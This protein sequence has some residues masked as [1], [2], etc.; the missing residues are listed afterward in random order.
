MRLNAFFSKPAASAP[1]P[2]NPVLSSPQKSSTQEVSNPVSPAKVQDAEQSSYRKEFPAFF[3]QSNTI[4]SPPHRFERDSDALD[5][6]RQKIDGFL[7]QPASLPAYRGSE[8]FDMV[9]YRRRNG[10]NIVSVKTLLAN[11]QNN[12]STVDPTASDASLRDHLKKITM[13]TIRFGEDVRP[14]YY[15]TF[16][17]RLSYMQTL[18]ICR[19]PYSRILP[20]VN[21]DYDSEGEWEEPEEG[22][23]LGSECEDDISDDGD[24]DMDGFL[25]DDEEEID[26]R[27]R[28]I[29]GDQEPVCTGIKWQENGKVDPDMEIYRI[30]SLIEEIQLPIDPFSTA[31]WPKPKAAE[32]VATKGSSLAVPTKS[33]LH[34]YSANASSHTQLPLAPPSRPVAAVKGKPFPP[35]HMAEFK[36][37]VEGCDLTKAGLI[38]VLKKRFPKV[39]KDTLKDTVNAV[40]VRVGQKEADKK[41]TCK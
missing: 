2:A 20:Q 23:E 14:P 41:W 38:E 39:S 5:H 12:G 6:I 3:L 21:Y 31:Y 16:T 18:K 33:T 1:K 25:D 4:L 29:A 13:K 26:G 9:P 40:A 32:Q 7:A 37:A 28:L 19:A 24:D 10:R 8:L 15:G 36:E 17:K 27:R 22:E 34:A 35:E 11:A 30:E